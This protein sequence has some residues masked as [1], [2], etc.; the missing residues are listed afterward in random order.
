MELKQRIPKQ[1]LDFIR[2][3]PCP[4]LNFISRPTDRDSVDSGVQ[5]EREFDLE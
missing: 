2:P 4:K 3:N 1:A 5:R